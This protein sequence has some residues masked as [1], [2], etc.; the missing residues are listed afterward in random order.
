[1]K[2]PCLFTSV[3]AERKSWS[4]SMFKV[5]L[6]CFCEVTHCLHTHVWIDT[7]RGDC[8]GP[9]VS[10]FMS[11]S[12]DSATFPQRWQQSI[13]SQTL[14]LDVTAALSW[15]AF[16]S[17]HCFQCNFRSFLSASSV[18]CTITACIYGSTSCCISHG[19]S[20]WERAIFDPPQLGDPS[21]DF[22]ETWNI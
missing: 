11:L 1:M 2:H 21:T 5:L 8:V 14:T 12:L 4:D 20:Q 3:N 9:M 7:M 13:R 15:D 18:H 6:I 17:L 19:P 10:A 22:H 16:T